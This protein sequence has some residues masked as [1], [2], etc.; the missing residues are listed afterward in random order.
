MSCVKLIKLIK[1]QKNSPGLIFDDCCGRVVAAG[2]YKDVCVGLR[3]RLRGEERKCPVSRVTSTCC[4]CYHASHSCC[5]GWTIYQHLEM[6]SLN[7]CSNNLSR[8]GNP[9]CPLYCL[10]GP[11]MAA[12]RAEMSSPRPI[13]MSRTSLCCMCHTA[14]AVNHRNC[15]KL[16]EIIVLLTDGGMY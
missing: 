10:S 12:V 7:F 2:V 11:P 8:Q 5:H 4:S 15:V 14:T 1:Q 16:H 6:K 3:R 9:A 13:N